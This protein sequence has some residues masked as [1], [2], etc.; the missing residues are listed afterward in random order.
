MSNYTRTSSR[1]AQ[2]VAPRAS[3]SMARRQHINGRLVPMD[4]LPDPRRGMIRLTLLL[5]VLF[6]LL[7]TV[8]SEVVRAIVWGVPA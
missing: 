6:V 5:I 8:G 3:V 4:D 2:W 1:P 7:L